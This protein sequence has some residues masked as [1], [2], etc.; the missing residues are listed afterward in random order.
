MK[1]HITSHSRWNGSQLVFRFPANVAGGQA[2]SSS[3]L[4]ETENALGELQ[5][6][7]GWRYLHTPCNGL[8]RST[9]AFDDHGQFCSRTP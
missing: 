8:H 3:P 4:A 5:N 7:V 1:Q 2:C 6:N 9:K